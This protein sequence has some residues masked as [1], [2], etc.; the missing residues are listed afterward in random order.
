MV[1]LSYIEDQLKRAGCNF[2]FFGR[3]EIRELTNILIPGEKI[4]ACVNG[5]YEGGFALLCATDHRL[6]LVDKKPLFLTLEDIR[7][8][9]ISE[10]DLN[11]RALESAAIIMTPNRRLIFRS[12]SHRRLRKLLNYSQSQ[13]MAI[14]QHFMM[15]QLRAVQENDQRRHTAVGSVVLQGGSAQHALP[16]NPYVQNS[17]KMRRNHYFPKF[18]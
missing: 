16:I 17:F 12:W 10:I 2:R 3:P 4:A 5:R 7:F 11:I 8:D 9:M 1:T 18:Y 15:Q 13:V 14:R 6:L